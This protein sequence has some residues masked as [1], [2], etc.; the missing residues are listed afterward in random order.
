MQGVSSVS[1]TPHR[2][3]RTAAWGLVAVIAI[4][5]AGWVIALV[6]I[7]RSTDI[8][9]LRSSI[10]AERDS[11]VMADGQL[12]DALRQVTENTKD[13]PALVAEMQIVLNKL[14]LDGGQ[15]K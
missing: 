2:M 3:S 11:R 15:R 6:G 8:E 4:A 12:V 14:G 13:V 10:A 5:V 9:A 7:V 1:D